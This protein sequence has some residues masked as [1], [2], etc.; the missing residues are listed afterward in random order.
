MQ[1]TWALPARRGT[2]RHAGTSLL[3]PVFAATVRLDSHVWESCA[4]LSAGQQKRRLRTYGLESRDESHAVIRQRSVRT[5]LARAILHFDCIAYATGGPS[6]GQVDNAARYCGFTRP[7]PL[8][9]KLKFSGV[10]L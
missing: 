1:A 8:A 4:P 3:R 6:S 10:G 7:S 5:G 9:I 2:L